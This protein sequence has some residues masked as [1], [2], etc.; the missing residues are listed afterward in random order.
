M[1]RE[2]PSDTAFA[3]GTPGFSGRF[4][5]TFEDGGNTIVGRVQLSYD[6][7][8]WQDDLQT[9]ARSGSSPPHRIPTCRT[10]RWRGTWTAMSC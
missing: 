4:V 9:L 7:E 2:Q 8:N 3:E 1:P 6:D 10:P 5:G